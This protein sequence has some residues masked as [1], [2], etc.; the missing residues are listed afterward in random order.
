MPKIKT[1]RKSVIV[2]T[3]LTPEIKNSIDQASSQ[4][5]I[6]SS[7]WMRNI[8][9]KELRTRDLLPVT[10]ILPEIDENPDR[11]KNV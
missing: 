8:I 5:G 2:T 10:Y 11:V 4:E 6:S 9:V 1:K 7:E 3:R